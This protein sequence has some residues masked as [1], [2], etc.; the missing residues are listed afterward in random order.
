MLWTHLWPGVYWSYRPLSS[1]QPVIVFTEDDARLARRMAEELASSTVIAN[2][3]DDGS[4]WFMHAS[5]L[6]FL[7]PT[8]WET[9]VREGTSWRQRID[10]LAATPWPEDIAVIREAG[11][12]YYLVSDTLLPGMQPQASRAALREDPRFEPVMEGKDTTLFRIR[13]ELG[14]TPR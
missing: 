5:G 10:Q 6:R 9:G 3:N 8:S 13:W 1:R 7:D 11:A 12:E 2:Q 4:Y 14:T